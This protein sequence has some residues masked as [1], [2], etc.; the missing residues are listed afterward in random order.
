MEYRFKSSPAEELKRH[1]LK[2][3]MIEEAKGPDEARA[4]EVIVRVWNEGIAKDASEFLLSLLAR[5]ELTVTPSLR[6]RALSCVDF[7][8][9][10]VWIEKAGIAD[11]AEDVFAD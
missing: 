8:Q 11:S 2:S 10:G 7:D 3:D 5:R 6:E 1:A 4:A 9:L